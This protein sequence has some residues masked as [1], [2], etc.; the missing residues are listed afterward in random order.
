M[1]Y[2]KKSGMK[3]AAKAK[4]KPSPRVQLENK[5]RKAS[6]DLRM[7]NLDRKNLIRKYKKE[8]LK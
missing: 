8:Y 5:I 3:S 2:K 1:P 6:E 4:K 7:S